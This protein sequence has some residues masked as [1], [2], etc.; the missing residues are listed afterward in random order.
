MLNSNSCRRGGEQFL[1]EPG[2]PGPRSF[3]AFH[4]LT[5]GCSGPWRLARFLASAPAVQ[6]RA[7]L[8][9]AQRCAT[10]ADRELTGENP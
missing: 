6:D 10:E 2:S 8:D 3:T 9:L 1:A 5:P 4:R 7:W